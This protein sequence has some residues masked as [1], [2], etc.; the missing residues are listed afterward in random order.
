MKIKISVVIWIL[1]WH[2][3][4]S[5]AFSEDNNVNAVDDY[6]SVTTKVQLNDKTQ[7]N[8]DEQTSSLLQQG[9]MDMVM[10]YGEGGSIRPTQEIIAG[11]IV[12]IRII[13]PENVIDKD[14]FVDYSFGF[15]LKD[16][17]GKII[18]KR[19]PQHVKM[20]LLWKHSTPIT[21][22]KITIPKEFPC[23][24][25]EISCGIY[26]KDKDLLA[27]KSIQIFVKSSTT[28]GMININCS[29]SDVPSTPVATS[30]FS[31]GQKI[32]VIFNVVGVEVQNN[33]VCM[34]VKTTV[35]DE[36][37][38]I[39]IYTPLYDKIDLELKDSSEH[40]MVAIGIPGNFKMDL[41]KPGKYRIHMEI[42]DK[43]NGNTA[44]YDIPVLVLLPPEFPL[45]LTP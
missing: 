31:V 26:G 45:P 16:P 36:N 23:G 38:E 10:T 14:R 20:D 29:T 2:S 11:E 34:D 22:L 5:H 33:H 30:V 37:N 41:C 28:F 12:H 24:K 27:S 7:K 19:P 9:K 6:P 18:F 40:L 35:F 17:S 43:S 8:N 13:P 42:E 44:M 4:S 32:F 3:L 39:A 21:N 15:E 25:Y 1:I